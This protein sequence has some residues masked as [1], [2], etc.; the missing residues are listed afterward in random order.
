MACDLEN[1]RSAVGWLI[2]SRWRLNPQAVGDPRRTVLAVQPFDLDLHRAIAFLLAL[3]GQTDERYRQ[4]HRTQ[5]LRSPP[6][7]SPDVVFA[8]EV[9]SSAVG[10]EIYHDFFDP[11][12]VLN[13]VRNRVDAGS[14]CHALQSRAWLSIRPSQTGPWW[15]LAQICDAVERGV[16]AEILYCLDKIVCLPFI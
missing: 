4:S 3:L 6:P 14:T 5:G 2:T 1:G 9:D 10:D 7:L 12:R 16:V 13:P 8:C 15:L 11:L